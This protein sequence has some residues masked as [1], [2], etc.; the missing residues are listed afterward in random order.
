M[1]IDLGATAIS[2]LF[3]GATAAQKAFLGSI[4]LWQA[5]TPITFDAVGTAGMTFST[6]GTP[7]TVNGSHSAA[8]GLNNIV[9]AVVDAQVNGH[10]TAPTISVKYDPTGAN[11]TMTQLGTTF[12]YFTNGSNFG[13]LAV[14]Y[15][16]NPPTGAKT[17][18]YTVT[19]GAG[20]TGTATFFVTGQTVS[21][22]N[23]GS[24][25][26][27]A[28]ASGAA[29]A[30]PSAMSLSIGDGGMGVYFAGDTSGNSTG[31]HNGNWTGLTGGNLRYAN[32]V[33]SQGTFIGIG[34]ASGADPVSATPVQQG[35]VAPWGVMGVPLLTKQRVTPDALGTVALLYNQT[36][37]TSYTANGSHNAAGGANNV[38]I[39]Y[40]N[41]SHGTQPLPTLSVIYDPGGANLAMTQV[42]SGDA[43]ATTLD[44]VAF[45]LFNPPAGAKTVAYTISGANTTQ[46]YYATC[47]TVSYNDVGSIGTP[48]T[49]VNTASSAMSLPSVPIT[50]DGM[51]SMM[52]GTS[53]NSGSAISAFNQTQRFNEAAASASIYALIGEALG[54]P[55]VNFTATAPSSTH[56]GG[57]AI[58]MLAA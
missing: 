42:P 1:P 56:W 38:V 49:A 17:V 54:A 18:A 28:T 31:N 6:T 7:K 43:N 4:L 58:P 41:V 24:I 22:N 45:Y 13:N 10:S 44:V 52:F 11:I 21:M 57:L 15:L 23:V 16:F 12:N 50:L 9:I 29:G 26:T 40:M 3:V 25:G 20:G 51:V 35:N 30:G 8:G 14:F 37:A 47:N 32:T 53:V 19:Q 27:R 36:G 34:D 39:A 48:V 2:K 33:D 55:T 46:A 5:V